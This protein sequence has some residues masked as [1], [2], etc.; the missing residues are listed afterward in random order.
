MQFKIKEEL[1]NEKIKLAFSGPVL[2]RS[3][4]GDHARDLV[5]MLYSMGV[6]DI[7]IFLTDWGMTPSTILENDYKFI[8]ELIQYGPL[9]S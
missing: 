5:S 3:G 7:K 9:V 1:K 8:E 4:Y 6:F 2:S